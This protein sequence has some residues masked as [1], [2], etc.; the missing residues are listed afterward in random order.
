[1]KFSPGA[2]TSRFAA[3]PV[4]GD[5]GGDEERFL[6]EEFGQAGAGL[7]FLWGK[8][9]TVTHKDLLFSDIYKYIRL[10]DTSQAFFER[11]F[12][13]ITEST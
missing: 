7:A 11:E 5:Q 2:F 12:A 6:V 4:H 9:A 3:N 13:Q 1:M 10:K 8:V